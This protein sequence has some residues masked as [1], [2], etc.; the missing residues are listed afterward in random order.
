MGV[1][2]MKGCNLHFVLKDQKQNK[3]F[4]MTKIQSL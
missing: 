4:K 1:C 3:K 2:E